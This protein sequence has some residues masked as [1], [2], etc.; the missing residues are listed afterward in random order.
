MQNSKRS[1]E[2]K[3][4]EIRSANGLPSQSTGNQ[5]NMNPNNQTPHQNTR[6]LEQN[7]MILE[8]GDDER[9]DKTITH[10]TIIS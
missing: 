7:M 4:N 8:E 5:G 9:E 3:I 2:T 1:F 6:Y 10:N